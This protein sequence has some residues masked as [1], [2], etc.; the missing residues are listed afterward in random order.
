MFGITITG[1]VEWVILLGSLVGAVVAIVGI[2]QRWVIQPFG[3]GLRETIREELK[4]ISEQVDGIAR[5]VRYNGGSSLKD[6]VRRIEHR[7]DR[8]DASMETVIRLAQGRVVADSEAD[9]QSA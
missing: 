7:Q 1:W 3:R 9:V 8:L 6:V 5:E 4:P 2:V